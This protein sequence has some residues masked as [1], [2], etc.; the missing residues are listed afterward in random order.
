[1]AIFAGLERIVDYVKNFKFHESDLAYLKDELGYNEDFLEY[2]STVR[3]TGNIKSVCEG[4]VVFGN[5]PLLRVEAPLAEAQ[6]LETAL[7]NMLTIQTLFE[8][9]PEGIRHM[10]ADIPL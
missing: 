7:L 9:K 8:T 3:F 6:L 5:E 10:V 1:Y 4:E 2:L